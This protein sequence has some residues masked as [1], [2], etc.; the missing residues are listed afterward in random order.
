MSL[1]AIISGDATLYHGDMRTVM[2]SAGIRADM[3]CSDVPYRLISG[4]NTTGEMGGK[5]GRSSYDN[6][7]QITPCDIDFPDFMPACFAAMGCGHAYFMVNN[8]N[9]AACQNAAEDAGFHFHN[10]LVWDKGIATP[11]RWYMKN[12]EFTVLVKAGPAKPINDCASKQLIKC[13]PPSGAI[14][15]TQKP[16]A[17]MEHYIRNSTQPGDVVLDPFMGSGTTGVAALRTGR[18]FIG[19][20]IHKPHFDSAVKRISEACLQPDM[21]DEVA[22]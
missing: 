7:G 3:I 9:I 17:L 1:T 14:H 12:L 5:F 2:A 13:P 22:A 19:I 11:N 6:T 21:F 10:V 16:V 15:E 18:K 20:E 8:R 4:G